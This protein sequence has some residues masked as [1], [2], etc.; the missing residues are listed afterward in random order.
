MHFKKSTNPKNLL[1]FLVVMGFTKPHK[2]EKLT[3]NPKNSEIKKPSKNL[4]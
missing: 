2:D 3:L 4:A 1:A